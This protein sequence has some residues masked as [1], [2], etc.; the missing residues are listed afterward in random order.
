MLGIIRHGGCM[1]LDE[2]TKCYHS[3]HVKVVNL[4]C[5]FHFN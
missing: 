4:I 2:V 3:E 1:T 5:E